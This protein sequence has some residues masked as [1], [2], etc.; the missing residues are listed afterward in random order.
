MPLPP[1]P[2][3]FLP[4]VAERWGATVVDLATYAH[5]GLIELCVMALSVPVAVGGL[6]GDENGWDRVPVSEEVRNGPQPLIPADIWPVIQNR[7]GTITRFKHREAHWFAEIVEGVEPIKVSLQQLLVTREERDR[8]EREYELQV[9]EPEPRVRPEPFAH[10]P[11]Y[12]DVQLLGQRFALG[13]LQ[14]RVVR[15]LHEASFEAEPWL[16]NEDLLERCGARSSRLV[17]LFKAKPAWRE[18][19]L[20]DGK[21][22]CRLNLPDR[23]PSKARQ[24]AFRRAVQTRA[25]PMA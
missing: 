16:R 22:R 3:F 4:E 24:R 10:S 6:E 15:E 12:S 8:F 5:E 20:L 13:P 9:I 19:I 17:D 11:D 23:T 1:K 14:A 21:G 18:L 25:R 7:V 2:Y